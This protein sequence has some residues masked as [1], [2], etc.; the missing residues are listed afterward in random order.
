MEKKNFSCKKNFDLFRMRF[1]FFLLYEF[2][3]NIKFRKNYL[4]W[5]DFKVIKIMNVYGL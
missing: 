3:E 1:L 4:K 5:N 2:L